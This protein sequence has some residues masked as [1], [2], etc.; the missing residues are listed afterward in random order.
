[1]AKRPLLYIHI[2][3]E[4]AAIFVWRSTNW[5]KR[6]RKTVAA[7]A[8]EER[9]RVKRDKKSKTGFV[10]KLM[11]GC[12]A[13]T[14]ATSFLTTRSYAYRAMKD[15]LEAARIFYSE[16]DPAPGR[17]RTAVSLRT[18]TRGSTDSRIIPC[19]FI[20]LSNALVLQD[21]RS[22]RSKETAEKLEVSGTPCVPEKL[23]IRPE[24]VE[25]I[26]GKLTSKKRPEITAELTGQQNRQAGTG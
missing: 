14:V 11:P 12:T 9:G 8:G 1:M 16:T 4:L 10:E 19:H 18:R 5:V 23:K 24:H 22:C 26:P 6:H 2:G 15:I 3:T 17:S 21:L 13:P 20:S 25:K 7:C